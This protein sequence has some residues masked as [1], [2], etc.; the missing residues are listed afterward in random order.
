[1]T[2]VLVTGVGAI[3]GYGL[4]RTLRATNRPLRL[5]GTDI[6]PDAVGQAWSDVFVQ[7]P[8]TSSP[9]YLDWLK[10]VV[11]S[12]QVDLIIPGI[13]QD[14][15]RYS[16]AREVMESWRART[17]LNQARLIDLSRDKWLMHEELVSI[18]EPSVIQSCGAGTFEQLASLLGLPFILKPRRSYASKGI[19]IVADEST[20]DF[21]KHRLGETL[22][23]QPI[24]GSADQEY[25]VGV[26]GDGRG[27]ASASIALQRN[28][29]S[30]GSTAKA[31]VC[32]PE[33]LSEVVDRLCRHFM[34]I[35]PTN[36]QFRLGDDGWKLLEI[37]PRVSSSTS[38][39]AAFGYNEGA[40][41]ID[42][43]CHGN[44]PYQPVLR[45]GSATRFIEDHVTYDRDNL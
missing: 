11:D 40:M 45:R 44:L 34:P 17:V 12:H 39:R 42:F 25:T 26:F 13:E 7:A 23:A 22:I 3:I 36:L 38:L 4:L 15:H 20:F 10:S 32:E 18:G 9:D 35:G 43:F 24:V 30:D 37:N 29:A 33:G 21:H 5:V 19:V 1:M 27:R 8:L 41:C 14:L 2:T 31:R 28:L 6:Y 16:D